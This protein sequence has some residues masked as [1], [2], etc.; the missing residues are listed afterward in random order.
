MLL[1]SCILGIIFIFLA[2]VKRF[3]KVD[4]CIQSSLMCIPWIQTYTYKFVFRVY[5][6]KNSECRHQLC[7]IFLQKQEIWKLSPKYM[8]LATYLVLMY[9]INQTPQLCP[10]EEVLIKVK[11]ILHTLLTNVIIKFMSTKRNM[12]WP[13]LL[14]SEN[15]FQDLV[16]LWGCFC[17]RWAG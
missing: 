14:V 2:F 15:T 16:V 11:I 3:N 1:I 4:V 6:S 7:W 9:T 5:T 13:P 17:C 10:Q 12:T 8:K